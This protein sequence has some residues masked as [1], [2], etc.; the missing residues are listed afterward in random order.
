MYRNYNICGLN[1]Q[2]DFRRN[3]MTQRSEKY[4]CDGGSGAPDMV[5]PYP[6]EQIKALCCR[7]THITADDAENMLTAEFFYKELLKFDG[8][9][10]HSSAVVVDGRAYL[11]SA[12]SGTGKSTHTSLWLKAFGE[13]AYIL[14]DDKPALR[15]FESGEV[16]AYGTPWSGKSDLNVNIGVPVQGICVLERAQD[17]F[18]IPISDGD[19]AFSILNQTIRP[20]EESA[21]MQ[22]LDYVDRLVSSVPVWRMGCNISVEAAHTAYNA[23]SKSSVSE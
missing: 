13:R 11:F 1:V 15:F 18:I 10:L 23:M 12:P 5:I 9:M 14:N 3:T 4:L 22:L 20:T 21:M 19:A 7:E 6:E 16:I 2:C 8:F 17:N